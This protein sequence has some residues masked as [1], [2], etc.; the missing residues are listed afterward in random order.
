MSELTQTEG[1]VFLIHFLKSAGIYAFTI[2]LQYFC[3]L[4]DV[5]NIQKL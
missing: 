5:S 1:Y 4:L 3:L 2:L